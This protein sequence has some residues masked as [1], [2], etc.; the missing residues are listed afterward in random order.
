MSN[1]RLL[2]T[3]YGDDFTGSTDAMESFTLAGAKTALFF[4]PPSVSM[5][6]RFPDVRAVGVAGITRSLAPDAMECELRPA[7]LRLKELASPVVQYKIC[8]TFDSSPAVGSIGRVIDIARTVFPDAPFVPLV[9]GAPVL[10]RYCVFG[11]LFA[12][13]GGDRQPYRIDRH[14]SMSKHPVTPA[15]ES[16]L[17][18]HLGRQ[19]N[20]CISLFDVLKYDLPDPALRSVLETL[21]AEKAEVVLFDVLQESHL[22]RIGQLLQSTA[23]LFAVG[24][25][26]FSTAIGTTWGLAK[27]VF[28][29]P[30]P[31]QP[32]LVVSGS[33]SPVTACQIKWAVE[34]GFA[35][36]SLDV[37]A[38][39]AGHGA[40]LA[41]RCTV[42]TAIEQLVAGR[43]VIIHT[44]GVKAV[45]VNPRLLG[46]ALG[47]IVK[48]AVTRTRVR[49][50]LIAGGDTS[51]YLARTL[52]IDA[53]EM[54]APLAPGAPLC[55]AFA[56]ADS[57]FDGLELNFKGGQVGPPDY[58]RAVAQGTFSN[59]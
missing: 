19:T 52:G 15:D 11:N 10:G 47:E 38:I 43:H 6:G 34:H 35:E 3:F 56:S 45:Q 40:R 54:I 31:A 30:G 59:N 5:L 21:L 22:A 44:G 39:A 50:V 32:L 9:V 14:P 57:P 26:G 12:T 25:S 33:C 16:D 51:G 36:A 41:L 53:L 42:D 4:K 18:V 28:P 13:C 24:S 55:R 23:P 48:A 2:I 58:F 17:R 29:N 49:R 37:A 1:P 27:P 8:S 46:E 7:L 20:K